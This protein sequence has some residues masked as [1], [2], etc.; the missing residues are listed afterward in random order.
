MNAETWIIRLVALLCAAGSAGLLWVFG[1]FVVVPWR[2]GR[3]LAL[4][5][6][7]MQVLGASLFFGL[8]T[9]WASLHL[10]A[11]GEK[12]AHPRRYRLF[13][14]LLVAALAAAV[15]GGMSWTPR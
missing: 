15:V 9:G 5:G 7:E 4:V 3:M 11:L 2:A 8:L 13:R 12:E 1:V 10:L 6:S 14:A